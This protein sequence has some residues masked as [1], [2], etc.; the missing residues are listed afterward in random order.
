MYLCGERD[1]A[2]SF[3]QEQVGGT[4]DDRGSCT[5]MSFSTVGSCCSFLKFTARPARPGIVMTNIATTPYVHPLK[6]ENANPT[7]RIPNTAGG[8]LPSP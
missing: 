2:G 6:T 5:R 1:R 4:D 3:T 7:Y 8:S